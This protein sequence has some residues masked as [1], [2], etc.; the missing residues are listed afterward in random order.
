MHHTRNKYARKQGALQ[1]FGLHGHDLAEM[2][3]FKEIKQVQVKQ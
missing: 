3:L 2:G 1:E